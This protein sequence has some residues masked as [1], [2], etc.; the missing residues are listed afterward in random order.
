MIKLIKIKLIKLLNKIFKK[1]FDKKILLLSSTHIL[2]VRPLYKNV[3]KITEVEFKAFSQNGEDGIIDYLLHSLKIEKPTFVEVGVG[4]YSECNT[5]LLYERTACRGLIVD[6]LDNLEAKVSKNIKLWKGDLSVVEIF[7]NS[8]N[9]LGILNKHKFNTNIDL[10]S[11]DI[12]GIDYWVLKKLPS[13]FSKIVITEFNGVFGSDLEITVPNLDKFNRS[14]YHYSHLCFGASLK[15]I[16]NLMIKKN[17][18]FLGANLSSCNAFFVSK[19]YI[20][21]INLDLPDISDIAEYV[22]SYIRESRSNDGNLSYLSG[23][24]R[25]KEIENCEVIDLKKSEERKNIIKNLI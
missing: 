25:I 14:D 9:I 21:E 16:I 12:D 15:A 4:D 17:F 11:L 1:Y 10:F 20:N 23:K 7:V 5:R 19:K 6:C 18:I 22:N 24:D 8:E 13:N 2:K 3:K